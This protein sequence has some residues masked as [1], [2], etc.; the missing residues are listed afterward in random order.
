MNE[1]SLGEKRPA[2][3]GYVRTAVKLNG[4]K[5]GDIRYNQIVKEDASFVSKK[6]NIK[7]EPRAFSEIGTWD[8]LWALCEKLNA[9]KLSDGKVQI[10]HTGEDIGYIVITDQEKPFIKEQFDK[11]YPQKSIYHATRYFERKDAQRVARK[12]KGKV[13][14]YRPQLRKYTRFSKLLESMGIPING[15]AV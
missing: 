14:K 3:L 7:T 5:I 4:R 6:Y 15:E 13:A 10:D 8:I 1:I 2:F 9:Y 11:F 12:T